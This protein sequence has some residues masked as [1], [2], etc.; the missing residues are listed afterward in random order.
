MKI[1]VFGATGGIGKHII[2][3]A[4]TKG[5][6]VNAYVRNTNKITEKHENL[7]IFVGQV[8]DFNSIKSCITGCEVVINALGISM[9]PNV[10]DTSSIVAH[11]N[12][13]KAMNEL[14]IKR[15]IDWST[16]SIPFENDKKS[17][18]TVV[19]P[20]LAS[21]FLPKA[22]KVLVNVAEQVITSN[23]DWTIVRFMAP[24]NTQYTGKVKVGFG[25]VKMSFNISRADIA[26]FML[27]QVENNEF[28]GS[29]PI[30][31]S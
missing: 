21:I 2:T 23:L 25:D 15:F 17:I 6:E 19:P 20:I 13:I 26:Y 3:Q 9:K 29:M 12:I 24:K 22:K 30:I 11:T 31:G 7:T 10:N 18:I 4:L 16:P 8:D 27:K 14:S 5:Y 28:I 1:A